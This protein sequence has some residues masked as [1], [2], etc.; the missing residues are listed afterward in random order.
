M[1]IQDDD[2]DINKRLN[3]L[4]I[5]QLTSNK[6]VSV[7]FSVDVA[8]LSDKKSEVKIRSFDCKDYILQVVNEPTLYAIRARCNHEWHKIANN[9][10]N[11]YKISI[12]KDQRIK[13]KNCR[14]KVDCTGCLTGKK[15]RKFSKTKHSSIDSDDGKDE[16]RY[17]RSSRTECVNH[18][19]YDVLN[20]LRLTSFIRIFENS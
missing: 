20:C 17:Q 4:S 19:Y 14:C 9:N 2:L 1:K 13:I 11:I 15:C 16:V 3:I 7:S 10:N 5:R 18:R 8:T 12:L 6:N